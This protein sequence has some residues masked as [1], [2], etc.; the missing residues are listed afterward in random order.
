MIQQKFTP[1]GW[2]WQ[3]EGFF[4]IFSIEPWGSHKI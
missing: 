2:W 4:I 1:C 3:V